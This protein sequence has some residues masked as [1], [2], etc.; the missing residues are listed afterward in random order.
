MPLNKNMRNN[1]LKN[2]VG[3]TQHASMYLN[4]RIFDEILIEI[5][6]E[7]EKLLSLVHI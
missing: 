7:C 1:F 3:V 4:S 5:N 2:I 6:I